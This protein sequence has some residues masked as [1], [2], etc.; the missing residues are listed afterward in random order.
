MQAVSL[1]GPESE[2][3]ASAAACVYGDYGDP[4]APSTSGDSDVPQKP[5]WN[6]EG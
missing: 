1:L 6:E 5:T 4:E 3:T 2:R